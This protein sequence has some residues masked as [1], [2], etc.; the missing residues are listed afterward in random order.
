MKNL[1]FII[2]SFFLAQISLAQ[3]AV[4]N[5]FAAIDTK[6]LRLPDSL[7]RTTTDIS[8]YIIENFKTSPKK[9]LKDWIKEDPRFIEASSCVFCYHFFKLVDN[10]V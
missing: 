1:K 10:T 3:K 9:E 8:K 6:A 5:E 2:F 4:V 7:T